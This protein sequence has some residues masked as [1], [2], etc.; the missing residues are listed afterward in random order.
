MRA[1]RA[2]I[3]QREGNNLRHIPAKELCTS[4][5]GGD[6]LIE[7]SFKREGMSEGN[8]LRGSRRVS[9][10]QMVMSDPSSSKQ[11]SH[12]EL[13]LIHLWERGYFFVK[14]YQT[15][16]TYKLIGNSGSFCISSYASRNSFERRLG[17]YCI[18][19][20]WIGMVGPCI[21]VFSSILN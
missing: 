18:Q 7:L 8:P 9:L 13:Y 3:S 16:T 15:A 4:Q 20:I 17:M 5:V 2:V 21:R 6:S 19:E 1:T 12:L 14:R 11:R 10:L